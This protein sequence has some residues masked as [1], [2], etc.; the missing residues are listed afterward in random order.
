M[1]GHSIPGF[2]VLRSASEIPH[3]PAKV[4]HVAPLSGE[5]QNAQSTA[6][7]EGI[8][9]AWG[10]CGRMLTAKSVAR[11][12][13]L[14]GKINEVEESLGDEDYWMVRHI[15]LGLVTTHFIPWCILDYLTES[16]SIS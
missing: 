13:S 15:Y 11:Y 5:V 6:R 1:L 2:N 4:A 16:P 14:E 10:S 9:R 12:I 7:R 8:D 3:G